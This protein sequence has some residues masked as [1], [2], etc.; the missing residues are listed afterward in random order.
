MAPQRARACAALLETAHAMAWPPGI[1][2]D[3]GAG[4]GQDPELVATD[5]ETRPGAGE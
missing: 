2:A 3:L 1:F 5:A 4:E